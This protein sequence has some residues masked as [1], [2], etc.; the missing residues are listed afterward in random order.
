MQQLGLHLEHPHPTP[1]CLSANPSSASNPASYHMP[2]DT[3]GDGLST[4]VLATHIENP[5]GVLG[6]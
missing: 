2:W 6:S 1:E 4:S 5:N 3:A